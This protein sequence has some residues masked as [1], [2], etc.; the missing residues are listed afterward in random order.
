MKKLNKN[1]K[2]RAT[3]KNRRVRVI[4]ISV[5]ILLS[6]VAAITVVSKQLIT[7][8]ASTAQAAN[9]HAPKYVTVKVAGQEVQIDPQ[10]GHIK[11]M[12]PEKARQIAEELK[13]RLN[14]STD[15]LVQVRNRDGSVSMDLQGRA[16]NVMLARTNDDGTVERSCVDQ[17]LAAA[18]FLGIDPKLMGVAAPKQANG[19]LPIRTPPKRALQ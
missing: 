13:A 15:G 11:P 9:S 10:T 8:N 7:A 14:K 19:Q 4:T 1:N 3:T 12:T 17:P 16:Q 18:E 2:A 6:A 5:A